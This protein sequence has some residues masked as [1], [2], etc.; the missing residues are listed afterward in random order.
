MLSIID[1]YIGRT[2]IAT[3]MLTTLVLTGISSLVGY[4]EQLRHVGKGNYD[5][6]QA[7]FFVLFSA[8]RDL[9][10][11]FPMAAL[12]GGLIGL[13]MLASSSELVVMQASG[14]SKLD[15]IKSVM[16]TAVFMILLVMA[17]GEWVA[18]KSE[19]MAREIKAS[20]ISGGSLISSDRGIWAKDGEDFVHI[21]EV[22]DTGNL[23]DV[24]I[25]M[26]DKSINLYGILSAESARF[27]GKAWLLKKGFEQTMGQQKVLVQ[28][29]ENQRWH[30]SLT[31]EKLGV[32]TVKPESLSIEGLYKYLDYL[33]SNNQDPSRYELAL[34]RKIFQPFTVAVMLLL[35]LSFIFGPL[36][37]VTMGARVIMGILTGFLFHVSNEMF[38]P[39]S[40]VYELPPVM[41]A[42]VPSIL[43]VG[44]SVYFLRRR[45]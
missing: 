24:S 33:A 6:A 41:G 25:Y 16:K 40:I 26:F 32:V 19:A 34:W 9:E 23:K 7:F 20:A 35:A 45:T 17:L 2:I 27:E 5:L 12:I 18:P 10:I 21:G 39:M 36:R 1:L 22:Q 44:V 11:F 15:I 43:F 13:G 3:T 30:S 31:P 38:G 28:E 8:P 4:V 42:L 37:S 14:M 29:F